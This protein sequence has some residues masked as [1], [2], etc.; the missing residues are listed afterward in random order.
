MQERDGDVAARTE[1][2][3][4]RARELL[5]SLQVGHENDRTVQDGAARG[6]VAVGRPRELA[7]EAIDRLGD[8]VVVRGE[9]KEGSV[10]MPDGRGSSV[11]EL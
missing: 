9:V 8:H 10:V 11:T 4:G 3:R 2:A 7:L 5:G 6:L 1:F